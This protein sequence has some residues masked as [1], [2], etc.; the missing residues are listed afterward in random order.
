MQRKLD[1]RFEEARKAKLPPIRGRQMLKM[2]YIELE[3]EAETLGVQAQRNAQA[4]SCT[5]IGG[6]ESY[7]A[8]LDGIVQTSSG[9]FTDTV[10]ETLVLEQMEKFKEFELD[11]AEYERSSRDQ[12]KNYRFLRQR[13]EN[14]IE[15]TKRKNV[16]RQIANA[17]KQGG[18]NQNQ[19]KSGGPHSS[20]PVLPLNKKGSPATPKPKP[21]PK[22]EGST[23][24]SGAPCFTLANKGACTDPSCKY[25]HDPKVIENL[26]KAKAETLETAWVFEEARTQ[27]GTAFSIVP[28]TS[29]L[30]ESSSC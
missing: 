11:L 10:L 25:S 22:A 14:L 8:L 26:K 4:L 13:A 24:K 7:L 23:P 1:I 28:F 9:D 29:M 19:P 5:S 6:F 2:I 27:N 21:K 16:H 3:P 30:V 18:G 12:C 17:Y 15:R 20:L